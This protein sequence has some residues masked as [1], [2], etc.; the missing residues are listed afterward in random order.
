MC[1][2][3]KRGIGMKSQTLEERIRIKAYELWL[4]DGSI[5]GCADEY[6]H[7]ARQMIEAELSAERAETLRSGEGDVS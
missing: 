5:E 4:E 7:L 6:W 1:D 2:I 3:H